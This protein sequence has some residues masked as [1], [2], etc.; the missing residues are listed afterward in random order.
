MGSKKYLYQALVAFRELKEYKV[1]KVFKVCR[2]C[3]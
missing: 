2:E 3:K 1:I